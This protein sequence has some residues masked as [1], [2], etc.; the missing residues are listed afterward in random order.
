MCHRDVDP[1]SEDFVHVAIRRLAGPPNG[2]IIRLRNM[3][4][5]SARGRRGLAVLAAALVMSGCSIARVWEPTREEVLER[6][7][8]SSVQIIVEQQEGR[9]RTGSGVV[10]AST[11]TD[12]GGTCFIVTSGHTMSGL[13]GQK[14]VYVLLG[15]HRGDGKKTP[16]TIVA[17]R[18]APD[19]DLALLRADTDQCVAARA[20]GAPPVLGAS[21]WVV[22][23][24]WGRSMTLASGVVSQIRLDDTPEPD[25]GS[26]LMVDASVS[27]GA[28]GGG[29]Y[30]A[31]DG[32]LIGI[33]EGYSTAR[34]S[35]KGADPPWYI[36]VPV[37]GQ[38]YVT[39]M[40]DVTRFL[41][42]TGYAHLVESPTAPLRRG[43]LE[44]RAR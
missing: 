25:P 37:P 31:R 43:P 40:A 13:V 41:A 4:A 14:Q 39:S 24:P 33:V 11:R 16:A 12:D 20:G 28:S 7:L 10:I 36:D 8:P 44:T 26:R 3:P 1:W 19:F 5:V 29:V 35:S 9:V 38:T 6:I 32:R 2:G 42:S 17:S 18:D 21:V 23:F 22:G 15:R 34:V 27:Y 30:E